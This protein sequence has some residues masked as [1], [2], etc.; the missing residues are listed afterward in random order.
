MAIALPQ[1]LDYLLVAVDLVIEALIFLYAGTT[2]NRLP[3]IGIRV[4]TVFFLLV[5]LPGICVVRNEGVTVRPAGL[6]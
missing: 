6:G 4:L 3:T 5:Y 1:L 2:V